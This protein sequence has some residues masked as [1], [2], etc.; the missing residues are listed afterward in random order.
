MSFKKTMVYAWNFISIIGFILILV[1]GALIA[2]F[3]AIEV[4]H[5]IHN[6]YIGI[7]IYFIFPGI[8]LT[9]LALVPVGIFL[10]RNRMRRDNPNGIPQYPL[11]DLNDPKKRKLAIFFTLATV[12]FAVLIT[13]SGIK[14]YEFTESVTFC[15]KL[16]HV[17]MERRS[18]IFIFQIP[19]SFSSLTFLVM[20]SPP[21][22]VSKP[23]FPWSVA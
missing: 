4:M 15:G 17:A 19:S 3:Q 21:A 1:G 16:C 18:A 13:L 20:N 6:P 11:I 9:G 23:N 2:T 7:L 14:G 5:E 10:T 22:P 8:L 12:I